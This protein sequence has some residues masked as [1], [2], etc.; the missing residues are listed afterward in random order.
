MNLAR[1]KGE[2]VAQY[3]TQSA[4]ATSL[5][6]SENKLSR[7]MRGKYKINIDDA[8][9]IAKLLNMDTELYCQIFLPIKSPNGDK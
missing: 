2:I 5:G 1:L 6:W 8:E 9:Q 4:F 7:M 3:G